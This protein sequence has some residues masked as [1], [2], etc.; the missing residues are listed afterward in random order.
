MAAKSS[1]DRL[2][3]MTAAGAIYRLP[4]LHIRC[5]ITEEQQ[6][7]RLAF[8]RAEFHGQLPQPF[9]DGGEGDEDD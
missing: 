6:A 4:L 1:L 8:V 2:T 3:V 5:A 9:A 7:S